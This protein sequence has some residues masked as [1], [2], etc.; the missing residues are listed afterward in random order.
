MTTPK[1]PVTSSKRG[2]KKA[3]DSNLMTDETPRQGRTRKG[4]TLKKG[5]LNALLDDV[6]VTKEKLI[7]SDPII[8]K[9]FDIDNYLMELKNSLPS[10]NPYTDSLII[11]GIYKLLMIFSGTSNKK[12]TI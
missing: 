5:R 9:N 7:K 3:M 11:K 8:C 1:T 4:R 10:L 2:K 12:L 6:D